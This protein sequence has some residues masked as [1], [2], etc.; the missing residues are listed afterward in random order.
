M[1]AV[2]KTL[3]EQ[4]TDKVRQEM[5]LRGSSVIWDTE[6][7]GEIVWENGKCHCDDANSPGID[8]NA[9]AEAQELLREAIF[10]EIADANN[11][12]Q[13]TK[14]QIE[15]LQEELSDLIGERRAF[16]RSID[17]LI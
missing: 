15:R 8:E 13:S 9:L 2:K 1:Y 6:Q 4:A 3:T 17:S 16:R 12:E 5:F 11:A 14:D 10:A 7:F